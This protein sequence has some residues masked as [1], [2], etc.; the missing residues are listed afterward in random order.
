MIR[1]EVAIHL[2]MGEAYMEEVGGNKGEKKK[3]KKK[4]KQN[5]KKKK[6][7]GRDLGGARGREEKGKSNVI[8]FYLKVY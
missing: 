6:L 3:E 8:T 4:T 5:K 1:R 2:R 7:E